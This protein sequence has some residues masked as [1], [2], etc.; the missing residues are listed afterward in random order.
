MDTAALTAFG[1]MFAAGLA[2]GGWR[3]PA[4][5]L[6]NHRQLKAMRERQA[7]FEAFQL[8]LRQQTLDAYD[9]PESLRSAWRELK[10][11]D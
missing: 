3:L 5:W 10:E 6:Q 7:R 2:L 11:G 8:E 4:I 9:V 1:I